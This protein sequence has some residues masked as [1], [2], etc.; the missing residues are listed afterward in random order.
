MFNLINEF[1][2]RCVKRLFTSIKGDCI[3]D[4]IG[5]GIFFIIMISIFVSALVNNNKVSFI[6]I[7]SIVVTIF[8]LVLFYKGKK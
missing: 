3:N 1:L 7:V 2:W 5:W 8:S 4:L 6:I